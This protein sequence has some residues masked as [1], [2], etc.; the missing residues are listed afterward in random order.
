MGRRIPNLEVA[1]LGDRPPRNTRTDTSIALA[2]LLGVATLFMPGAATEAGQRARPVA[3]GRGNSQG[4]LAE[5]RHKRRVYLVATSPPVNVIDARQALDE[6]GYARAVIA[7]VFNQ[8]ASKMRRV[9]DAYKD[10]ANPLK[11]YARKYR[12]LEL[13]ERPEDADFLLV[14]YELGRLRLFDCY[15]CFYKPGN[16]SVGHLLVLKM[17]SAEE[18]EPRVILRMESPS[19]AKEAI[20]TFIRELKIARGEK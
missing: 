10:L 5:L 18:P 15:E 7:E 9:R 4:P 3:D 19:M 6:A 16:Y 8:D 11:K 20:Q 12:S 2:I 17:G 1:G 13:V 14:Y